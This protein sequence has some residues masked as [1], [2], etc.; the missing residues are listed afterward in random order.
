MSFIEVESWTIKN[1]HHEDHN[2]AIR[3]WF[4]YV[5]THHRELFHEWKSARYFKQVDDMGN[6][7]GRYIMNFEF[8][9]RDGHDAYKERR[10]DW[11]GPYKGYKEVDPYVHFNIDSVTLEY[12]EPM[13]ENL[14]FDFGF[15]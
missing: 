9:T 13:E 11:S 4:T 3:N 8:Y 14:W 7:T 15:K 1:G 6:P 12:W 10:K 5:K 2:V